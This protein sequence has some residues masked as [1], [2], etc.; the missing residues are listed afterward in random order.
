MPE[1]QILE[2]IQTGIDQYSWILAAAVFFF[3]MLAFKG[4]ISNLYEGMM[5]WW[6]SE[7]NK[8]DFVLYNGEKARIKMIGFRNT[9]FFMIES[10]MILVVRNEKI[11]NQDIRIFPKQDP[12]AIREM[13]EWYNSE[14]GPMKNP[15]N[16]N[17]E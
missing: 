13:V 11:K 1:E 12:W 7:F 17:D 14:H 9:E 10:G 5:F 15:P 3:V 2:G 8:D 6:G 4:A 16:N